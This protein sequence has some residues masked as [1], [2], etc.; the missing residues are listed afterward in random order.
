MRTRIRLLTQPESMRSIIDPT[1]QE[2]LLRVTIYSFAP[3][4]LSLQAEIYLST[5]EP[6]SEKN[7]RAG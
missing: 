3:L 2:P 7:V 4:P 5:A 1:Q 6:F